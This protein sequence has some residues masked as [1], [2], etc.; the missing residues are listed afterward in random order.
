MLPNISSKPLYSASIISLLGSQHGPDIDFT[1]LVWNDFSGSCFVFLDMGLWTLLLTQFQ[2][3]HPVPVPDKIHGF[4]FPCP[5][6]WICNP[7]KSTR[8]WPLAAAT[9]SFLCYTDF[10][11]YSSPSIGN[12]KHSSLKIWT[13]ESSRP[14]QARS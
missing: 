3:T 1:G 4:S 6:P 9:C 14:P 7:Q 2:E 11:P 13:M 10:S 8:S 5:H 12:A